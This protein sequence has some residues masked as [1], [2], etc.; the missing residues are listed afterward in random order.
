MSW[1]TPQSGSLSQERLRLPGRLETGSK[2]S[3]RNCWKLI[4][5]M[6]LSRCAPWGMDNFYVLNIEPAATS[7]GIKLI[8]QS[9]QRMWHDEPWH[10]HT[11][12]QSIARPRGLSAAQDK[13][14]LD[15]A[16][17]N[18]THAQTIAPVLSSSNASEWHPREEISNHQHWL[19][20]K[21]LYPHLEK[22]QFCCPPRVCVFCVIFYSHF[23]HLNTV[24]H[25]Y[26]TVI[27][28]WVFYE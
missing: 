14:Q 17:A 28:A 22:C 11:S 16:A 5:I 19:I 18:C 9:Y 21:P 2:G 1:A 7:D 23:I 4:W 8:I 15:R 3:A 10:S 20:N 13:T 12:R 26:R 24:L 25:I 6:P 27:N